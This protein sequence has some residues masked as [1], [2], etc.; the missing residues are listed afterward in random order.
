MIA[1]HE[2]KTQVENK[3]AEF[4]ERL[5]APDRLRDSMRYSLDA[6]GKRIR[7][8]LIY[9]VLDAFSIDRSK[10]DA[11]AAALE[12]IHTYSLIHDDLPAMD[13]DDLRRGRPTNHIAFDEATAILAGDALL[14]NAFSCL[15]ETPASPEVKLVLVERL[16]A[17]A[18]ASGMVGG[19]LDDMLGERGGINDVAE[20][21]SIHRRKTGALLVFA[22]EAGGLLAAVSP[23]D[24]EHLHQYGRHLGIAFQIQDDILDVTGDAKKIGKPVGSDEENEKATYPKLLGLEGAKR[25]LTAQ[26]EAAEQAIEALSVEATTLKELLDFVVKRD[27]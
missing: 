12:M 6:G 23:T 14:T 22:V 2:W 11:T 20:L 8:A 18:G 26:V 10:G 1:L 9:A 19:Q 7:P 15:L 3:M 27:H 21:E 17:A 16:A 4:M 25:A 24:L 5:D 13:D